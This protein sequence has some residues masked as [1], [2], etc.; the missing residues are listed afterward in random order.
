MNF[1]EAAHNENIID[2]AQEKL[3]EADLKE[4]LDSRVSSLSF[5]QLSLVNCQLNLDYLDIFGDCIEVVSDILDLIELTN[6][7]VD[8]VS[9]SHSANSLKKIHTIETKKGECKSD[10][11][12]L[13]SHISETRKELEL[14]EFDE[15]VKRKALKHGTKSSKKLKSNETS[16]T[17]SFKPSNS[18]MFKTK[19]SFEDD[20]FETN[21]MRK[22][23]SFFIQ[24]ILNCYFNLNLENEGYFLENLDANLSKLLLEQHL[25]LNKTS[26]DCR[27]YMYKLNELW[28][29]NFYFTSLDLLFNCGWFMFVSYFEGFL[30][31]YS[32]SLESILFISQTGALEYFF[33]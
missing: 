4:D 3:N 15:F 21:L 13:S 7:L 6:L 32:H 29:L 22:I 30:N 5:S 12:E 33:T 8:S 23:E 27:K 11:L 9:I 24:K 17:C 28:M 19:L 10:S 20:R 18:S 31:T 16:S 25:K 2:K 26:S 1:S 14:D